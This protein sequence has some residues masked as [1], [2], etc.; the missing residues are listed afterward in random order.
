VE[1][2]LATLDKAGLRL[3]QVYVRLDIKPGAK[4]V[5]D[6][7]LKDVLPMLKGRGVTLATLITGGTPSDEA[8]DPEVVALVKE[9]AGMAQ[10][11][12]VRVALYHHRSD[13]L[14][15]VEDCV[16]LARK[17]ARPDVGAM[18][19]L[20]HWLRVGEESQ[21]KPLLKAATPHL[22]AVTV[23]G[24]DRGAEI[25][26]GK[27]NWIQ[28]LDGGSFDIHSFLAALQEM[29]YDG[30]IG[31]QCYG[32]RGDARLHLARSIAAWRKLRERLNAG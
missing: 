25:K 2:R 9:I 26:S 6:P 30:P 29:G 1:E 12:G 18:F 5:Y 10:P 11:H 32:I 27:G 3:F 28:P 23:N 4:Q 19:N 22:L 17:V 16:R 13:W 7:R 20:C 14:E 31:L 24:T 8:R 21:M 15:R